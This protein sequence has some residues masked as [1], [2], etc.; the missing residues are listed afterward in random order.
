MPLVQRHIARIGRLQVGQLAV[1]VAGRQGVLHQRRAMALALLRRVHPDQRQ[2][3]MHKQFVSMR[4]SAIL[5]I[6]L[7]A[8]PVLLVLRE[9]MGLIP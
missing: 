2:V 4:R 7:P 1:A 9:L 3:P 6:Q 5:L 8:P